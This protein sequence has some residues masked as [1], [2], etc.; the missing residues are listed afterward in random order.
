[1]ATIPLQDG[2]DNKTLKAFE[3]EFTKS[4]HRRLTLLNQLR[5]RCENNPA[6][7]TELWECVKGE[8]GITKRQLQRDL[9]KMAATYELNC[10]QRGRTKLWSVTPDSARY[11]LPV[12]DENAALAFHLAEGLLRDLLPASVISSLTLWFSESKKL[13]QKKYPQNPWYQRLTTKREGLAL[14]PPE[15]DPL[16]LASV[17]ANLKKGALLKIEYQ[18]AAGQSTEREIAP[19]GIVASNQTLYVLDYNKKHESY[20]TYALHRIQQATDGYLDASVPSV[21][22]FEEYVDWGFNEFYASDDEIELVADFHPQVSRKMLE[23]TLLENQ[24]TQ[25][26]TD[27]WLRVTGMLYE[28]SSLRTWLLGYGNLVRVI[29]PPELVAALDTLRQPPPPPPAAAVE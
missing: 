12:L 1:M 7:T 13:L 9:E 8:Q 6:S 28:T 20:T 14:D 23:Y 22:D 26:L 18:S 29:S 19:A 24:T 2:I 25:V 21:D 10:T 15:I 17:F 4:Q 5:V 16:I 3:G 27:K 11:V